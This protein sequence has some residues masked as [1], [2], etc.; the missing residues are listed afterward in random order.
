MP[1]NI[2]IS[3]SGI[4]TKC[5]PFNRLNRNTASRVISLFEMPIKKIINFVRLFCSTTVKPFLKCA[6]L[7][8]FPSLTIYCMIYFG[9]LS[10]IGI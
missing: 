9:N 3:F 10:K 6:S 1:K 4:I 2:S 8:V 5:N 7:F